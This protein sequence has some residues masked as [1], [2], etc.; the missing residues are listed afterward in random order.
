MVPRS[1]IFWQYFKHFTDNLCY[2]GLTFINDECNADTQNE[3]AVSTTRQKV[4]R[5]FKLETR[6][7]PPPSLNFTITAHRTLVDH[8]TTL[9]MA[10]Y[11]NKSGFSHDSKYIYGN[12]SV[13]SD[14]QNQIPVNPT[15]IKVHSIWC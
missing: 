10:A 12:Q 11:I 15:K 8:L 2:P 1:T 3:I 13:N 9:T 5:L 14:R 7:P 6:P 4:Q